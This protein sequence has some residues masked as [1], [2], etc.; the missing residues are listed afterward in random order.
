MSEILTTLQDHAPLII[1]GG[2]NVIGPPGDQ[3]ADD[4]LR[5]G[6]LPFHALEATL[7][8]YTTDVCC[9]RWSTM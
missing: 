5:R 3:V 9:L 7:V 4:V 1:R 8:A 2:A 6:F